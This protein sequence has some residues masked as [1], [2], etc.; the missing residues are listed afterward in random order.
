MAQPLRREAGRDTPA[1]PRDTPYQR[2]QDEW[3]RNLWRECGLALGRYLEQ[4]G[5]LEHP[6]ARLRLDELE[7]MALAV[8]ARYLDIREAKRR[9]LGIALCV[10]PLKPDPMDA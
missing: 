1:H 8:V 5:H 3:Q 10:D 7:G 9:E 2:A 6:I 4:R